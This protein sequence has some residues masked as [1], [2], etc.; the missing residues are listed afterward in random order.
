MHLMTDLRAKGKE[1]DMVILLDGIERIW[2]NIYAETERE[3]AAE[4]RL[5][6]LAFTRAKQKVVILVPARVGD[7]QSTVSRYIQELELPD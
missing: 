4:R 2:P 1:F 3:P 7:Q 6:Y 5:F